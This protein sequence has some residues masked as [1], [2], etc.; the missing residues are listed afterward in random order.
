LEIDAKFETAYKALIFS[1]LC[2]LLISGM[3]FVEYMAQS[4][5]TQN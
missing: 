4:I 1:M 5:K 2:S 3:Y